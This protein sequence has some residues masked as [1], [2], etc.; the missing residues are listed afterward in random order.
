MA[1]EKAK[2][3]LASAQTKTKQPHDCT[4]GQCQF[5]PGDQVLLLLPLVASPLQAN[6]HGPCTV[7]HQVSEVNYKTPEHR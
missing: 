1:G 7:S 6:F 5:S 4:A 2:E 3:N